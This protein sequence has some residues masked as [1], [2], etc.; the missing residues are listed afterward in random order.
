VTTV[1]PAE[2]VILERI[3]ALHGISPEGLSRQSYAKLDTAQMKTAWGRRHRRRLALVDGADVLASATQY[4]LAAILDQRPVR[5]CG[6]GEIFPSL[7]CPR[8]GPRESSWIGC[9]SKPRATE[10][11]WRS[12]FQT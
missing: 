3:R 1:V 9:S 2:G 5:V 11:R 4:K 8:A 6:I 7:R 10:R 12:S